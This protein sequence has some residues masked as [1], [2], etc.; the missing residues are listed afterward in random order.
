MCLLPCLLPQPKRSVTFSLFLLTT[1]F[2]E[3]LLHFSFGFWPQVQIIPAGLFILGSFFTFSF[4]SSVKRHGLRSVGCFRAT[5][6]L[7]TIWSMR[8]VI[9]VLRWMLSHTA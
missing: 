9:Y 3:H 4:C 8:F 1:F 6:T 5:C 2:F 7:L